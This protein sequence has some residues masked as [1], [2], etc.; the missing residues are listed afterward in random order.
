MS[1]QE[2]IE[3]FGDYI[4][5]ETLA[6]TL[7]YNEGLMNDPDATKCVVEGEIVYFKITKEKVA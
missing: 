7:T 1:V 6:S 4:K 2:A 5:E 3:Q